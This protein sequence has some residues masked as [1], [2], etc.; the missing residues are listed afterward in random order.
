MVVFALLPSYVIEAR[1]HAWVHAIYIQLVKLSS[2]DETEHL[3]NRRC[4]QDSNTDSLTE[5]SA[6]RTYL[7]LVSTWLTKQTFPRLRS[8]F[9]HTHQTSLPPPS[10]T[11]TTITTTPMVTIMSTINGSTEA[12]SLQAF[13][14]GDLPSDFYYIPN[15]ITVEE[16]Q[17][18]LGKARA[19]FLFPESIMFSIFSLYEFSQ[20]LGCRLYSDC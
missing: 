11:I 12:S 13:R 17:S 15:F 20:N 3:S 18:M 4:E 6:N 14:I 2:S 19:L 9:R 10:G 1:I 7:T 16:E 8:A 5:M